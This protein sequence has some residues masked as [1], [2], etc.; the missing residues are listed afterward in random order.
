MKNIFKSW[1]TTIIGVV[2]IVTKILA[3]HG[4]I[5][6]DDAAIIAGGVGLVLC[7]DGSATHTE[8]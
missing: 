2:V 4:H 3:L 5:G 6:A 1:K 8:D 7:K